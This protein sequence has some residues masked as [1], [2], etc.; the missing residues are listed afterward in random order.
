MSS[1]VWMMLLGDASHALKP[2]FAAYEALLHEGDQ[3]L[4]KELAEF[5]EDAAELRA[6][7]EGVQRG[8]VYAVAACI[9]VLADN[10]A[11]FYATRVLGKETAAT[12][13][14]SN[15]N[16]VPFGE[17]LRVAGNAARHVPIAGETSI[18]TLE[19][20]GIERRD[21]AVPYELLELAGIRTLDHL[22]CELDILAHHI[23]YEDFQNK[24]DP[25]NPPKL[26]PWMMPQTPRL[27][28]RL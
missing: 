13:F 19:T 24:Y 3:W 18:A 25:A 8:N 2:L 1:V 20:V 23:D 16:G 12:R 10:I 27:H 6:G 9:A 14:G 17:V 4:D 21:D 22:I 7:F 11:R 28:P 26:E 5:G 15:M